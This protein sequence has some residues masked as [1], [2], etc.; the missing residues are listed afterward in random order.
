TDPSRREGI[1]VA[2]S[3][4]V[5]PFSFHAVTLA[6]ALLCLLPA[7]AGASASARVNPGGAAVGSAGP[8]A[9]AGSAGTVRTAASS[10]HVLS[11]RIRSVRCVPAPKCS[12]NPRQVSVNGT[13]LV[14]GPG[15]RAGMVVAF[16]R[17]AGARISSNSPGGRLRSSSL[18][19]IVTVPGSAHSGRIMVMLGGGRHTSSYGP[20]YVFHHALHPPRPLTPAGSPGGSALDGQGMWI[21]Y[22]SRS[23]GGSVPAIAARAHATGVGT[24]LVKSSD[25]STNYWSQFS[26]RLVQELHANGLKVCAWQYVYGSSPAGPPPPPAPAAAHRAP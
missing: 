15:L 9:G 3:G 14:G 26:S 2:S 1:F 10:P 7:P 11:V 19:L 21:W 22:L 16:P 4:P 12:L 18:G 13:L 6:A 24:V 8:G 25:G 17:S 23:N 5:K 20:I